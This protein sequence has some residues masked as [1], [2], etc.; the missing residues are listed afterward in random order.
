[1]RTATASVTSA[2]MVLLLFV[3]FWPTGGRIELA[4]PTTAQDSTPPAIESTTADSADPFTSKNPW[5]ATSPA[6]A[7]GTRVVSSRE[8][9]N[10]ETRLFL[11]ETSALLLNNLS[12]RE[13]ADELATILP[14]GCLVDRKRLTEEGVEANAGDLTWTLA[15]ASLAT[16]LEL[17]LDELEL[18]YQI[19]DGILVITTKRHA[20]EDLCLVIYEAKTLFNS[21]VLVEQ[22]LAEEVIQQLVN[23]RPLGQ[24][25]G[26]ID[27]LR[28]S[29]E[30]FI[31][32]FGPRAEEQRFNRVANL[33]QSQIEP[34]SWQE[35]GGT[36]TISSVGTR[37]VVRQAERTHRQIRK[38]LDDLAATEGQ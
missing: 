35:N 28:I 21:D 25:A 16:M 4:P 10:G 2:F 8:G 24:P 30:R 18:T 37:L 22:N 29:V 31:E 34:D 26:D 23:S 32:K 11:E 12:I 19:R 27:S 13:L 5:T 17:H 9:R 33:I 14:Y 36:A 15:N 7:T 6:N 3:S 1:M 38:L 20:E